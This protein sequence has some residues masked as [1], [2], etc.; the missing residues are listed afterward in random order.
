MFWLLLR[1]GMA[2]GAGEA[3]GWEE[4]DHEGT[5]YQGAGRSQ[6][7]WPELGKALLP[8]CGKAVKL[9]GVG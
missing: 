5:Q 6:N 4:P 8:A 7:S 3:S 9:W 1:D 2:P